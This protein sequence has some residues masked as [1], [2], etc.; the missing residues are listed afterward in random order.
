MLAGCFL[1]HRWCQLGAVATPMRGPWCFALPFNRHLKK[2][3]KERVELL[4]DCCF[5]IH[6]HPSKPLTPW[7]VD[8]I[9]TGVQ[10]P[11]VPK[12]GLKT[13]RSRM[14]TAPLSDMTRAVT[15]RMSIFALLLLTFP[16]HTT[17]RSASPDTPLCCG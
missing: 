7:Q 14:A 8:R 9:I 2:G 12:A 6:L 13:T 16:T 10:L 1:P 5:L 4:V 3:E 15:T 11:S 17:S